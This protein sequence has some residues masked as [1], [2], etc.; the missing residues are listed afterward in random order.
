MTGGC[1]GNSNSLKMF[2][3]PGNSSVFEVTHIAK[4]GKSHHAKSTICNDRSLS[5]PS[6]G[7]SMTS[8]PSQRVVSAA[9][10][11]GITICR[12]GICDSRK[13]SESNMNKVNSAIQE[14]TLFWT[15]HCV[16]N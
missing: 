7:F 14:G 8:H 1:P 11:M 16:Y 12:T 15:S 2:K 3:V 5:H 6:G 10:Q 13:E 9:R 4:L